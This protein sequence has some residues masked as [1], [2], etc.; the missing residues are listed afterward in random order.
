[1]QIKKQSE[2]RNKR[3]RLSFDNLFIFLI[4]TF[5]KPPKSQHTNFHFITINYNLPLFLF[6]CIILRGYSTACYLISIQGINKYN[7]IEIK[8]KRAPSLIS[9]L[10]V[11]NPHPLIKNLQLDKIHYYQLL[12]NIFSKPFTGSSNRIDPIKSSKSLNLIHQLW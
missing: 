10:K 11:L 12:P 8:C 1:M 4:L 2:Y 6:L 9:C 5:I 7:K 3:K